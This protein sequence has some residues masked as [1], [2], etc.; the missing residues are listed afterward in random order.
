MIIF[1]ISIMNCI[2]LQ[3]IREEKKILFTI[4]LILYESTVQYR[5]VSI[6]TC[7]GGVA[8]LSTSSLYHCY[9]YH[10]DFYII[11]T[12]FIMKKKFFFLCIIFYF[13][14]NGGLGFIHYY[15]L[16]K[17]TDVAWYFISTV[18][19]QVFLS[20]ELKDNVSIAFRFASH[21]V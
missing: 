19:S 12:I 21:T 7:S 15:D 11:S 3:F 6:I 13:G 9:D 10:Y 1:H 8:K 18:G 17:S 20:M 4:Y 16:L 2:A 5:C 14:L